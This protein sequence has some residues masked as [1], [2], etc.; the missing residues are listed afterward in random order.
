MQIMRFLILLGLL[1]LASCTYTT[2][3][4]VDVRKLRIEEHTSRELIELLQIF[5]E[6]NKLK[7]ECSNSKFPEERELLIC[8]LKNNDDSLIS[9]IKRIE[10]REF[11]FNLYK[12]DE[13]S[14]K[15]FRDLLE[16]FANEKS[17]METQSN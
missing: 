2:K 8:S 4:A 16:I 9:V 6:K 5:S 14:R 11:N 13:L 15:L 3:S 7:I 1:S 12:S 17:S 10:D